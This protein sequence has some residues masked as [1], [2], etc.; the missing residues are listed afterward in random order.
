MLDAVDSGCHG[1]GR[2]ARNLGDRRR[3]DVF[4]IE[5]H[6]L[7]V[8]RRKALD[9]DRQQRQRVRI[10][11]GVFGIIGCR[12]LGQFLKADQPRL[13]PAHPRGNRGIVRDAI[14]PGLERTLAGEI[15]KGA[16]RESIVAI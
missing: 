5:Q 10:A 11:Y 7:V 6:D 13:A 2:Q 1:A 14:D 12:R 4:Q 16:A 8:G 3:V 15:G 9:Q